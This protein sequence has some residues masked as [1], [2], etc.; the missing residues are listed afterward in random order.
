MTDPAGIET[1]KTRSIVKSTKSPDVAV[2][3][4]ACLV[5]K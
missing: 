4:D 1:G 5:S 3:F 2:F